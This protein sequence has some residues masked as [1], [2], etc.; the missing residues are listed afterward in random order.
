MSVKNKSQIPDAARGNNLVPT[1][2]T[3][4]THDDEAATSFNLCAPPR[5]SSDLITLN[6]AGQNS[7]RM[8]WYVHCL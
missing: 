1:P 2:A 5:D 7:T 8:Q 3:N 4:S 6:N